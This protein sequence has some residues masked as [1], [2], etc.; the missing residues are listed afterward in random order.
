MRCVSDAHVS[1]SVALAMDH[2]HRALLISP[3]FT[4]GNESRG[5]CDSKLDAPT[6][7]KE[8]ET[9]SARCWINSS[10]C[11]SPN[12]F[13]LLP[14]RKNVA[15]ML[16]F[17]LLA[18][19]GFLL[20]TTVKSQLPYGPVGKGKGPDADGKYTIEAPGIRASFI[21]YGASISNLFITDQHGVERDLVLGFD[22]ASYY[23]IDTSHPHLGG[24]PGRYANR[25]KN[26]YVV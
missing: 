18:V 8:F 23:S 22:N 24:V 13:N 10:I 9:P 16:K 20:V 11:R 2:E 6:E 7:F 3:D 26:R 25:I 14:V 21:P 4:P 19:V 1:Y 12:K 15:K 5:S 17:G